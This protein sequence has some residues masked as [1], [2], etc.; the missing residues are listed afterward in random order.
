MVFIAFFPASK[1]QG[2]DLILFLPKAAQWILIVRKARG[3]V[4]QLS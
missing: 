3:F 1:I 4:Q 2:E